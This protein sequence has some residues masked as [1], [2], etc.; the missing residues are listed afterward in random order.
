MLLLADLVRRQARLSAESAFHSQNN[1]YQINYSA[2]V[3]L[4][5]QYM[6]I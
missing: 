4:N 6:Q 3:D 1:G 5:G 2:L